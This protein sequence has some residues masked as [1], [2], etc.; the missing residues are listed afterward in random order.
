MKH[1]DLTQKI[2]Q[3]LTVQSFAIKGFSFTFVGL[4]GN[5]LKDTSNIFLFIISVISVFVFW[6]LDTYYLR[7][8]RIYRV[9][10]NEYTQ[11][12]GLTYKNYNLTESY[13]SVAFSRTVWPIYLVQVVF[14]IV[15]SLTTMCVI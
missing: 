9:V 7:M 8:E 6:Y 15:L 14:V 5:I 4:I 3:R 2:I 13:V 1:L 12:K 10:E 11:E